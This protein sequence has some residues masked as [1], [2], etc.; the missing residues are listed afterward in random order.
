MLKAGSSGAFL[1]V[2]PFFMA[3]ISKAKILDF[4]RNREYPPAVL[5]LAEFPRVSAFLAH[6]LNPAFA[7][8][9]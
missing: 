5:V 2:W 1:A 6:S 9:C 3:S 7:E 4:S 8:H